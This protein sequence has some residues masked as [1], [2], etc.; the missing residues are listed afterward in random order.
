MISDTVFEPGL[1]H[2]VALALADLGDGGDLKLLCTEEGDELVRVFSK[3]QVSPD[4]AEKTAENV[5]LDATAAGE[6]ST[7]ALLSLATAL[8]SFVALAA[9]ETGELG[10]QGDT[11]S[12][13]WRSRSAVR[14]CQICRCRVE[15]GANGGEVDRRVAGQAGT[16]DRNQ[17]HVGR[18]AG[19]SRESGP[20]LLLPNLP[21][22]AVYQVAVSYFQPDRH[23]PSGEIPAPVVDKAIVD[24]DLGTE[25]AGRADCRRR[26]RNL[27]AASVVAP[28]GF[29]GPGV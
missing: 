11:A 1:D 28:A 5:S 24:M 9:L 2:P 8:T 18:C 27:A 4:L 14:L 10:T 15:L 22:D 25:D 17:S 20:N 13:G 26:G 12:I 23:I 19:Y 21:G 7:S 3:D 29:A 6:G 16:G